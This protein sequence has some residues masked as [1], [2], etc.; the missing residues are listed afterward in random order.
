[1]LLARSLKVLSAPADQSSAIIEFGSIGYVGRAELVQLFL[2]DAFGNPSST[3]DMQHVKL[4][5][6]N[7]L[8]NSSWT[9]DV[10]SIVNGV[11][12][13]HVN[14]YQPGFYQ[15]MAF[16]KSNRISLANM[17]V[18]P[19]NVSGHNCRV[20]ASQNTTERLIAAR[21]YSWAVQCFDDHNNQVTLNES[22]LSVVAVPKS[23]VMSTFERKHGALTMSL[24]FKESGNFILQLYAGNRIIPSQMFLSVKTAEV[25]NNTCNIPPKHKQHLFRPI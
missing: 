23:E 10:E 19:G 3:A 2:S 25:R 21:V 17:H 7:Q 4:I 12:S 18:F 24:S 11:V 9:I 16:Y 5:A 20:F 14:W 1:M 22:D 13:G 8:K 15:I 6:F